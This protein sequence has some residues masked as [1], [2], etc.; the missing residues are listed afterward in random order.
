MM[1]RGAALA[2]ILLLVGLL[3]AALDAQAPPVRRSRP[4]LEAFKTAT[5]FPHGRP[6]YV[7]D[8]VVPLCAGGVDALTNLQWQEIRASYRKDVYER[9]LCAAMKKQGYALVK[10]EAH[11]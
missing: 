5:G 9:A 1:A 4:L 10:T 8:H 6:G 3:W 7:I 11:P 2:S